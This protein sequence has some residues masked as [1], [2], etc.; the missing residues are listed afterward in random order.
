MLDHGLTLSFGT[1][2]QVMAA[3][4]RVNCFKSIYKPENPDTITQHITMITHDFVRN[5]LAPLI[6]F[7]FGQ[8]AGV[9]LETQHSEGLLRL[10]QSAWNWNSMLKEEVITLGDF[11]PTVYT[12]LHRFDST[13]MSKFMSDRSSRSKAI[14][15][16]MSIGLVSSLAVGDGKAPETT[17]VCKAVVATSTHKLYV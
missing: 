8:D 5:S 12:P 3:K 2:S 9:E 10:V 14:L 6:M 1:E 11:R 7:F 15:G 4:W 13:L 17:V 16:T